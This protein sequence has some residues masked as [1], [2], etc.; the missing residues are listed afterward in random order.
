MDTLVEINLMTLTG[1]STLVTFLSYW[2][3]RIHGSYR[4]MTIFEQ[5]GV[6]VDDIIERIKGE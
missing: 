5:H 6:N 2:V 1:I 4:T 3:G